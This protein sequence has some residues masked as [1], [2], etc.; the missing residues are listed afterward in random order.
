MTTANSTNGRRT[1]TYDL[2]ERTA[3][4]GEAVIGFAKR[5]K[6]DSVTSPLVK[7]LVRA[8]TSIGAN[9]AE[10]DEA[11]SKKEFR[12]RISVCKRE[13]KETR[14]WLRMIAAA[15]PQLKQEARPLW[16]E[17]N[18]L[19]LIFAAIFRKGEDKD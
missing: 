19:T 7:Q 6:L 13:A 1:R 12:Y 5:V 4:F 18:E 9:Y 3:Q 2:S 17:A 16:R 11:G 15:V 10:A 8:A 14:H